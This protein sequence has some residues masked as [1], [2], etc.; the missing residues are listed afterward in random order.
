MCGFSRPIAKSGAGGADFFSQ[1]H[2]H[3]PI[4]R[5][6]HGIGLST[7]RTLAFA[8]L[9]IGMGVV[10]LNDHFHPQW[11]KFAAS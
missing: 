5:I 2:Q 8:A 7:V 9:Q 10:K 4:L 6:T 1:L 3:G 11:S